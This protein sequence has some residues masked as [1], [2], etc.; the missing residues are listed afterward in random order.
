MKDQTSIIIAAVAIAYGAVRIYQKYIKKDQA[1]NTSAPKRGSFSSSSK[2][3]DYE[4]YSK[5]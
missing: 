2:E 1:N 4:P 3:D 5:K